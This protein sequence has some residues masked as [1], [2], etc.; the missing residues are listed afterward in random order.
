VADGEKHELLIIKRTRGSSHE[1]HGGAWKI[2]FADFMTAM[3]ALFLVLWLI[4]ATNQKTKASLARYFNPV[5]LVDMSTLKRG[6]HD[7]N[8]GPEMD[9]TANGAAFPKTVVGA[10]KKNGSFMGAALGAA[11]PRDVKQ[12]DAGQP[13][14]AEPPPVHS[15]ETLF[16]DPYAVLAEI[17]ASGSSGESSSD[18]LDQ[19]DNDA[20][21]GSTDT[22][23][24]PFK[25]SA[26]PDKSSAEPAAAASQA[27]ANPPPAALTQSAPPPAASETPPPAPTPAPAPVP[28]KNEVQKG[29]TLSNAQALAANLQKQITKLIGAAGKDEAKPAIEV[30]ATDEGILISLT[31]QSNFA[32]FAIGSAEPQAK[33]VHVMDKIARVL[34]TVKGDIII[35]GFTDGRPYR[36]AIYD[37]WRLSSARAQMAYYMLVRGGVDDKRIVRIEGYADRRP[38]VPSKPLA[39]E[40][41]RIEIFL[42]EEKS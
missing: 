32:M 19:P 21:G 6:M 15:E 42:K 35:G 25:A 20:S 16:R 4:N 26:G 18:D 22:Y 10:A 14:T 2:A 39:D 1:P 40:N 13:R 28:R 9:G 24:D 23:S 12:E 37:N 3:M 17:A 33:T 38:K 27:A 30:K 34:K 29:P 11:G 41:R 31:D 7:P 8:N 5:D 36:S